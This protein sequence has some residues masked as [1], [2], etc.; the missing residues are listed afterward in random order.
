MIRFHDNRG[1]WRNTTASKAKGG[2][3]AF[4]FVLGLFVTVA[5]TYSAAISIRDGYRSNTIGT[6]FSCADNSGSS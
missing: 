4:I 1:V 2:Y 5:G 6:A 3:Y